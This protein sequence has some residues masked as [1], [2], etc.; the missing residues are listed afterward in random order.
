M[1]ES[2]NSILALA[3]C[4]VA[5]TTWRGEFA[6]NRHR[7]HVAITDAAGRLLYRSGDAHRVTLVRSAAK[8]AQAL[9]VL[10]TTEPPEFGFDDGDLALLCASH[11]AEPIHLARAG[12]LLVRLGLQES[13]LRCGAHPSLNDFVNRTWIRCDVVPG[14]LSSNCSGK[15]IG[16]LAAARALTGSVADYHQPEH[17]LQHR[18]RHTLAELVCCPVEQIGWAIDG[19]NLPTPALP[20]YRLAHL[21]AGL[22]AAADRAEGPRAATLP[23]RT[24]RLARL[25]RAIAQHP[26][27]IAGTGRFCT[28]L[29]TAF[30]GALI[31]KVGADGCYAVGIRASAVTHLAVAAGGALGIA[32]KV[33]DGAGAV[34]PSIVCEV[35]RQLA[36]P[37]PAALASFCAP[38]MHNT[39]GLLVGRLELSLRLHRA[40]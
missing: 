20:L 39:V 16:M 27:L 5:A 38:E 4:E 35:L 28:A 1:P 32:V 37:V 19:C 30:D 9:A 12:A 7:V 31:G 10:E 2:E 25:Y 8:P 18:I 23:L 21:Y 22:A 6:E 33:E 17:L 24:H 15:H 34:V 11:S 29:V 36:L 14:P 13:D 40:D 3:A 26:T